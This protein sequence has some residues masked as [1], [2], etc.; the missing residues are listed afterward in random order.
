MIDLETGIG[1]MMDASR[2]LA[3]H[4]EKRGDKPKYKGQL[5]YL[6]RAIAVV[7]NSVKSKDAA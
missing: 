5:E 2:Q 1:F 6:E 3:E 4:I 7:R